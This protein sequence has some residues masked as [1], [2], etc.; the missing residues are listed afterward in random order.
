MIGLGAGVLRLTRVIPIPDIV[1]EHLGREVQRGVADGTVTG[2]YSMTADDDGNFYALDNLDVHGNTRIQKFST[3]GRYLKKYLPR[4]AKE[5]IVEGRQLACG[6][7]KK[8][9]V[10]QSDG[11]VVRLGQNLEFEKR[12]P[13]IAD[14]CVGMDTD[15]EGH[16]VM[17]I[18][19]DNA[20]VRFDENGHEISRVNIRQCSIIASSRVACLADDQILILGNE[21]DIPSFKVVDKD[22]NLVRRFDLVSIAPSEFSKIGVDDGGRIYVNDQ[23]GA[24]GVQIYNLDGKHLGNAHFSSIGTPLENSTDCYVSRKSGIL[25]IN[26]GTGLDKLKFNPHPSAHTTPGVAPSGQG[27]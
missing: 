4:N 2:T 24:S 19:Q 5:I 16:V 12:W 17:L 14:Y 15:E 9:Y 1:L 26:L 27:K 18:P 20:V 11:T 3:D 7:G 23:A 22:G 8:L 13:A 21:G 6:L 10:R 25:F